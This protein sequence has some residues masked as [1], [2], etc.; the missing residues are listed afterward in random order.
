[1][2]I[3]SEDPIASDTGHSSAYRRERTLAQRRISLPAVVAFLTLIAAGVR[4]TAFGASTVASTPSAQTL[5][6]AAHDEADWI[7][8]AKTYAGNRLRR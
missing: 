2:N 3:T 4:T 8:P 6:N 7:L 5:L 1:M